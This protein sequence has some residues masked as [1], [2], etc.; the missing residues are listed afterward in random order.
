MSSPTLVPGSIL[1]WRSVCVIWSG[2]CSGRARRRE[3]QAVAGG[4]AWAFGDHRQARSQD[5]HADQRKDAELAAYNNRL[6]Q[7]DKRTRD[8]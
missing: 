2:V 3:D 6:A 5:R 1:A 8:Q 7:L 4:M